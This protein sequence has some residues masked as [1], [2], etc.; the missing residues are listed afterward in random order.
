MLSILR[1]NLKKVKE[2]IKKKKFN[3]RKYRHQE[4]FLV[5]R[6]CQ[7]LAS[8]LN[9]LPLIYPLFTCVDPHSEFTDPDP[10]SYWI[11]TTDPTW[12]RINNMSIYC[13]GTLLPT[14]MTG[15]SSAALTLVIR[16]LYSTASLKLCLKFKKKNYK[17]K[18]KISLETWF[19][20]W[21]TIPK[22]E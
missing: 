20:Y 18:K 3:I 10:Q 6:D 9:V 7:I 15:T 11:Q 16:F 12:I 1:K 8:I 22:Y 17:N 13:T 19:T 2:Y 14:R 4:K 5:S 21:L